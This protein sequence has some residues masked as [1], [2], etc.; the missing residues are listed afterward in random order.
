MSE[1]PFQVE[2]AP[3]I[4]P[5]ILFP[6]LPDPSQIAISHYVK[7]MIV[8]LLGD[9]LIFFLQRSKSR[10][11]IELSATTAFGNT[12]VSTSGSSPKIFKTDTGYDLLDVETL[13]VERL[14]HS[15]KPSSSA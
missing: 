3:K 2:P 8:T 6:S 11:K 10:G 5:I 1:Y 4:S 7:L 15:S 13:M 14:L 9:F 12:L